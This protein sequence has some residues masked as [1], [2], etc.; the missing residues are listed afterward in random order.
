MAPL[1]TAD[2][3]HYLVPIFR[4]VGAVTS[5]RAQSELFVVCPIEWE[6]VPLLGITCG[7]PV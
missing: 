2:G 6:T 5:P 3:R 7:K 1:A 4:F